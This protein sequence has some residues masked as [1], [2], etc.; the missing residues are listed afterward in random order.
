MGR[1]LV[2]TNRN[3]TVIKENAI[4]GQVKTSSEKEHLL[5]SY[6][7]AGKIIKDRYMSK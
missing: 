1:I 3:A 5:K 4:K 7:I 2:N 6:D